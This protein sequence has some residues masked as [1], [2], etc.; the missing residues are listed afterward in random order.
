MF[1][2]TFD[3]P[4]WRYDDSSCEFDNSSGIGSSGERGVVVLRVAFRLVVV[5]TSGSTDTGGSASAFSVLVV[6][7]GG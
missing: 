3:F 2:V 5:M 7:E 6:V 4:E 1:E